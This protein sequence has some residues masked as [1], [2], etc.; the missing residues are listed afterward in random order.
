[1]CTGRGADVAQDRA[2]VAVLRRIAKV[3]HSDQPLVLDDRNPTNCVS[4]HQVNRFS[5]RRSGAS[6]FRLAMRW[7]NDSFAQR[8]LPWS[9]ATIVPG[10]SQTS[11]QWLPATQRPHNTSLALVRET[12][13]ER[14]QALVLGR[15]EAGGWDFHGTQAA[16]R[17]CC[18]AV[19][20]LASLG[21]FATRHGKTAAVSVA[22]DRHDAGIPV[23]PHHRT[24]KSTTNKRVI[25]PMKWYMTG[26]SQTR[27]YP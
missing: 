6:L 5:D 22:V 11:C 7:L 19:C 23:S 4:S 2:P 9:P 13:A 24:R 10:A 21:R 27:R 3:N 18:A 25:L 20:R 26:A 14:T 17:E 15:P 1:M 16:R 8:S 12:R